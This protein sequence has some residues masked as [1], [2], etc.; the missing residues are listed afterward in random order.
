MQQVRALVPALVLVEEEVELLEV[1]VLEVE[2]VEV[3]VAEIV[4]QQ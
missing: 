4:V 2:M 3:V 1:Q